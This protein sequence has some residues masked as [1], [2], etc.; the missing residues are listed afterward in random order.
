MDGT[1]NWDRMEAI[2]NHHAMSAQ[3][4]QDEAYDSSSD[5]MIVKYGP[6]ASDEEFRALLEWLDLQAAGETLTANCFSHCWLLLSLLA[7]PCYNPCYTLASS[8]SHC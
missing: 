2:N 1:I 7:H 4:E 5:Q 6:L 3:R 8:F